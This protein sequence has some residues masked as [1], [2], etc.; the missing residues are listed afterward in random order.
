MEAVG[1]YLRTLREAHRLSRA[2]V[3]SQIGT[4]ESQLVRIEAGEQDSRGSLLLAFVAIVQGRA[5]D[6]QRLILD[7]Q[8]TAEDG[9]RLAGEVLTQS[10][11]DS[12]LS[13]ADSDPKRAALLRRIAQLS[14]DPELRARIA[15]YLDAIEQGGR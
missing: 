4:H 11:R 10:E 2:A 5:N 7:Q 13:I 6:I 8:A 1:T 12:I 3:A 9:R 15:G 14:D